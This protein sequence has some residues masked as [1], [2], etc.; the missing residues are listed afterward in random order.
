MIF[1]STILYSILYEVNFINL[2]KLSSVVACTRSVSDFV[3]LVVSEPH[4]HAKDR[5]CIYKPLSEITFNS[6]SIKSI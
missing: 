2:G 4:A 5:V 6:K 3:Y 1:N